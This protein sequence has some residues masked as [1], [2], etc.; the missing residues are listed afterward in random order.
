M[1]CGLNGFGWRFF[2]SNSALSRFVMLPSVIQFCVPCPYSS[3]PY[4]TI[5]LIPFICIITVCFGIL[6]EYVAVLYCWLLT[7][8]QYTSIV[9]NIIYIF[10]L[11]LSDSLGIVLYAAWR[12]CSTKLTSHQT[13]RWWDLRVVGTCQTGR[14]EVQVKK[15]YSRVNPQVNLKSNYWHIDW[16]T[17]QCLWHLLP[18]YKCPHYCPPLRPLLFELGNI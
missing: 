2:N 17:T 1:S 14:A 15:Y 3:V 8:S 7:C 4:F 11:I 13:C 10:D 9:R 16:A 18:Y 5:Q 6:I 12:P